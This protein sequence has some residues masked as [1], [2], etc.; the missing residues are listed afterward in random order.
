MLPPALLLCC[1]G[2]KPRAPPRREALWWGRA[3]QARARHAPCAHPPHARHIRYTHHAH[4]ACERGPGDSSASLFSPEQGRA[5]T[6]NLLCTSPALP[7]C[8]A[9]SCTRLRPHRAEFAAHCT[10]IHSP[11]TPPVPTRQSASTCMH[12]SHPA[13]KKCHTPFSNDLIA[14]ATAVGRPWGWWRWGHRGIRSSRG[15]RSEPVSLSALLGGCLDAWPQ[16]TRSTRIRQRIGAAGGA[17]RHSRVG[18]PS[19]GPMRSQQ[20][21]TLGDGCSPRGL[22]LR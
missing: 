4:S 17:S 14:A 13:P 9:P 19:P 15:G 22:P 8:A 6:G 18:G 11:R 20:R 1:R 7:R 2:R 3:P 16:E 10:C 21:R 5:R 12:T